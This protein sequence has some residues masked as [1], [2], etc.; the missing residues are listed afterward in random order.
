MIKVRLRQHTFMH[1][2]IRMHRCSDLLGTEVLLVLVEG[3]GVHVI[4]TVAAG[5]VTSHDILWGCHRLG[6]GVHEG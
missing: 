1:A 5:S 3:T 6:V 4:I 2:V